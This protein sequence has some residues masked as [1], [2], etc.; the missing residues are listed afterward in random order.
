MLNSLCSDDWAS[1]KN[2]SLSRFVTEGDPGRGPL[3]SLCMGGSSLDLFRF[4]TPLFPSNS[5]NLLSAM[6]DFGSYCK[7]ISVCFLM[8][9]KCKWLS[10]NLSAQTVNK[11]C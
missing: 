4:K 5:L 8:L 7:F 6:R 1:H 3:Y 11:D 2:L 10:V 9:W